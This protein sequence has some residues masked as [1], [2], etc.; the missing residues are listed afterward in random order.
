MKN[1]IFVATLILGLNVQAGVYKCVDA[2]GKKTYSSKPCSQEGINKAVKAAKD[3]EE[4]KKQEE[5]EARRRE[6]NSQIRLEEQLIQDRARIENELNQWRK[7]TTFDLVFNSPWDGSV[8]QIDRYLES[9]LKDPDSLDIIACGN[10][11][12]NG[13]EFRV[14]CKYRARNSFGGYVVEA[15]SYKITSSGVVY[16]VSDYY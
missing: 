5:A 14:W 13:N 2:D 15:K 9:T 12:T 7:T 6:R 8:A 4:A 1:V 10:V 3:N 11:M 16:S